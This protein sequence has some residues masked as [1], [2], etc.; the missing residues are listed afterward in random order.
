MEISLPVKI[1][2][3][4]ETAADWEEMSKT[5]DI[6][7][8]GAA[9]VLQRTVRRGQ[10]LRL[11]LSMP[12]QM[13]SFDFAEPQYQ[14]WGVVSSSKP[15]P[16][17]SSGESSVLGVAFIGKNPPESYIEN[18]NQIY[19][20]EVDESEGTSYLKPVDDSINNS[21]QKERNFIE[22]RYSRFQ[23]PVNIVV[24]LLDSDGGIT[25]SESTVM[26]NVSQG[27]ASVFSSLN[28]NIGSTIQIKNDQYSADLE[29][30]VRNKRTGKDG[31]PR[32]HIEFT[33]GTFPLP[34]VD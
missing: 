2:G 17:D 16:E 33:N 32:L 1:Y 6:S 30:T 5:K 25:A 10:L 9:F 22:R 4:D 14:V 18:P 29:A 26:E 12:Q 27:G 8:F 15:N 20:V 21:G 24:E 7:L 3:K 23:I 34:D 31:I 11:T 28:V 19:E 13:R